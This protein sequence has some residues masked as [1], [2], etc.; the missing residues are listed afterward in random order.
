MDGLYTLRVLR[1]DLEEAQHRAIIAS[2]VQAGIPEDRQFHNE[3]G[4]EAEKLYPSGPG[5]IFQSKHPH[6]TRWLRMSYPDGQIP[7]DLLRDMAA[8]GWMWDAGM[9]K[10]DNYDPLVPIPIAPPFGGRVEIDIV[11]AKG[12]GLFGSWTKAE[13]QRHMREIKRVLAMHGFVK[14]PHHKLTLADLL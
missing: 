6:D 12:T 14:I 4:R 9:R 7:S 8:V 13:G 5:V 1:P 10:P 11:G 3:L 2:L